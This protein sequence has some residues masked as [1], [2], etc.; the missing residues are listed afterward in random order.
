ML[1]LTAHQSEDPMRISRCNVSG[2]WLAALMPLLVLAL[3]CSNDGSRTQ[4]A[5]AQLSDPESSG[6]IPTQP[7]VADPCSWATLP[8]VEA[9]IGKVQGQPWRGHSAE[10]PSR[11]DGGRACVYQVGGSADYQEVVAVEIQFEDAT[12]YDAGAEIATELVAQL[13]GGGEAE[14]QVAPPPG[15][16]HASGIGRETAFRVGHMAVVIGAH[17]PQISGD[18]LLKLANLVRGRVPD[19]PVA[20]EFAEPNG[21]GHGPN[22]CALVT[23]EEAEAVL[24]KLAMRPY[25]SKSTTPF[26][27]RNGE[28][29]S[30]YL[31][32]HRVLVL[33]AHWSDAKW[34]FG[35]GAGLTDEFTTKTGLGEQSADTLDGPW[36]QAKADLGGALNFLTGD[37]MLE[38]QYRTAGID[39]PA[40]MKLARIAVKRLADGP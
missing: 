37:R 9:L 17:G 6:A 19:V 7:L 32:Q 10:N 31:G 29:C 30:Y 38:V 28:A 26:A 5:N 4:T 12:R 35:A 20:A 2:R 23:R 8:E 33:T 27:D 1:L 24:G 34:L 3:A 40:A 13:S 14:G 39:L 25:R 18:N 16:D 11:Q 22:P 36:D 21:A 15:W